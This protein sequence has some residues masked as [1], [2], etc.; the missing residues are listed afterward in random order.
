MDKNFSVLCHEIM[1][2]FVRTILHVC[3]RSRTVMSIRI[4]TVKLKIPGKAF[5]ES[6]SRNSV[7]FKLKFLTLAFYQWI[8]TSRNLKMLLPGI[9]NLTVGIL[10][11]GEN[12][13]CQWTLLL[14]DGHRII[15]GT[16]HII[17][18]ICLQFEPP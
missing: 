17:W 16:V 11:H 15:N 1:V 7:T 2:H 4:P 10:M 13:T 8:S 12:R 3:G 6:E 18:T 14:M 9:S 5:L